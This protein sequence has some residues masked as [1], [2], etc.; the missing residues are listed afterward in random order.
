M[1]S[2][3]IQSD[4][5]SCFST[6]DHTRTILKCNA[7]Y[8]TKVVKWIITEAQCGKNKLD[9]HFSYVNIKFKSY[10]MTTPGD[11]FKAYS[12]DG[13]ITNTSTVLV[14]M[15]PLIADHPLL[16]EFNTTYALIKIMFDY[17]NFRD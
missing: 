9:V 14:Q 8:G 13:G 7:T 17:S 15:D 12:Y 2:V 1:K 16:Y 5:A 6:F 4:N 10:D 3:V 11:I